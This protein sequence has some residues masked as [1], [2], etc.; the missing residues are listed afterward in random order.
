MLLKNLAIQEP[1]ELAGKSVIL[2]DDIF[3]SG[4]TIKEIGNVLTKFGF[5][6]LHL[7]NCKN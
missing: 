1:S 4:A 3:D 7:S 6:K 5:R 2:F